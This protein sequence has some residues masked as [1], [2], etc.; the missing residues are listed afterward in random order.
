VDRQRHRGMTAEIE[1]GSSSADESQ[2]IKEF[3]PFVEVF[4]GHGTDCANIR[5]IDE[6]GVKKPRTSSRLAMKVG[7]ASA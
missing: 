5:E 7:K 6:F 1:I 2:T 3:G 4:P